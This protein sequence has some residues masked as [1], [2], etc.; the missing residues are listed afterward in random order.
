M[1]YSMIS[2]HGKKRMGL[3]VRLTRTDYNGSNNTDTANGG[4][5]D[6]GGNYCNNDAVNEGDDRFLEN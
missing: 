1:H 6:G 2:Q 3:C 4:S 5:G